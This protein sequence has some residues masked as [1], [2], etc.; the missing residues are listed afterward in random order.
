MKAVFVEVFKISRTFRQ[1]A[2]T[3]DKFVSMNLKFEIPDWIKLTTPSKTAKI[4]V[5]ISHVSF[6]FKNY[7]CEGFRRVHFQHVIY[8]HAYCQCKEINV[9]KAVFKKHTLLQKYPFQNLKYFLCYYLTQI[10]FLF[11]AWALFKNTMLVW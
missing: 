10:Y 6:I 9:H 7:N 3:P 2:H 11:T 8:V 1:N 5:E 4:Q